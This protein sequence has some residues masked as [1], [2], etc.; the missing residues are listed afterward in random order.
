MK[1]FITGATGFIGG[2]VA[3]FYSNHELLTYRRGDNLASQLDYF[4]PDII[5]N[6]A[7]EIYAADKMWDTN[8]LMTKVFLD[9]QKEHPGTTLVQIGSS[10][11]YGPYER[12]TNELDPVNPTDM[13]AGTK[14]IASLL[15]QTYAN[16]YKSDVVIIR[17][18]S[19]YGPGE[20]PHRLF[21]NLWR[22]FKLGKPMTLVNGVHDFCYIDDLVDAI[23]LVIKSPRRKPGEILNVSSGIQTSNLE[24]LETFRRVTGLAGNV[25]LV[26]RFVTPPTWRCDNTVIK[27]RY[28]W[29]PKHNLEQ[30]ISKFLEQAHYE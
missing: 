3:K 25:E 14:G 15:C 22:S 11:E 19:P 6:S 2:A 20:R 17:P 1:M 29:L 8:V 28:D 24:V 27:V 4:K 21:P 5:I 26:D 12:A 13:Y 30:G 10:S 18:Y 23:D 9:Y 16:V 7:A